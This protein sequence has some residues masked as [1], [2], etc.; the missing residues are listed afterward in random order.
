M[1][2]RSHGRASSLLADALPPGRSLT[3]KGGHDWPT[4]TKL[5]TDFLQTGVLQRDCPK[6]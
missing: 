5:W 1:L 2:R 4:W 3:E 6:K